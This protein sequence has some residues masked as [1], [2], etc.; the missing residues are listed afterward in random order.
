MT[1]CFASR[2]R[3]LSAAATPVPWEFEA[4]C[5]VDGWGASVCELLGNGTDAAN[6]AFITFTRNRAERIADVVEAVAALRHY[7]DPT[8]LLKAAELAPLFAALDALDRADAAGG[9]E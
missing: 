3:E 4:P 8:V 7:D 1:P 5:H 6:A 9:G 2:L